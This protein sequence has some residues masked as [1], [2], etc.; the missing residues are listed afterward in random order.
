[1][2]NDISKGNSY[3]LLDAGKPVACFAF[4]PGP[5]PTYARIDGGEWLS[6][7]PYHV[8]H[9]LAKLPGAWGVFN[10]VM[11]WCFAHDRNIRIDTHRD[12]AI[13]RHCIEKY[14]FSYCG[15]IYLENGDERLAYQRILPDQRSID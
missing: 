4:V 8:I 15:I 2:K 7:G 14:G 3:L 13:M 12:N 6:D 5:D 10:A 1:M 11:D 9:R